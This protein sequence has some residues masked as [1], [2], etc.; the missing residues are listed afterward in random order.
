MAGLL[1]FTLGFDNHMKDLQLQ[2]RAAERGTKLLHSYF[3][4]YGYKTLAVGKI[5]H[6]HVPEGSVD[7]SGGG[8]RD[9]N[10]PDILFAE[11][12]RLNWHQNKTYSDWGAA[13]ESDDGLIDYHIAK[14]AVEKLGERQ[15]EPFFMMVGTAL[16]HSP[17]YVPQKWF[18]LYDRDSIQL[19]HYDENDFDDLPEAS[20]RLN[21]QLPMPKPIGPLRTINGAISFMPTLPV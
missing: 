11:R 14:W 2:E 16:P 15:E 10:S 5:C 17:W 12:L 18:D 3:S 8:L 1:P 4:D 7:E 20:K 9:L 6:H 21:I 19:P 13:P